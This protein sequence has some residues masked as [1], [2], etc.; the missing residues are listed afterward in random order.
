MP[1]VS[2]TNQRGTRLHTRVIPATRAAGLAVIAL[3]IPLHNLL[4]FGQ[5]S[6]YPAQLFA[7]ASALYCLATWF[8]LRSRFARE[9]R[10]DL[11]AL[12]LATDIVLLLFAINLTGGPRS[13]LF[14]LLAARCTDQLFFGYRRVT[15]FNYLLIGF[16]L[17]FLFYYATYQAPVDWGAESMKMIV[18]YSFNVYYGLSA[19][20]VER[21]RARQH[22]AALALRDRAEFIGSLRHAI[23]TRASGVAAQVE[24]LKRTP[25]E[26]VQRS[27]IHSLAETSE[28]LLSLIGTLG[29]SEQDS[30]WTKVQSGLFQPAQLLQEVE[31]FIR[32]FAASKGVDLRVGADTDV[33]IVMTGDA[34]KIRQVLL[35]LAHNAVRFTEIGFVELKALRA[36]PTKIT[37]WVRD[38]GAGVPQHVMRRV[39]AGLTRADGSVWRRLDAGPSGLAVSKK[40]ADLMGGS[41]EI[42]TEPGLGTTARLTL[43]IPDIGRREPGEPRGHD[44]TK[45]AKSPDLPKPV[46]R[47]NPETNI[48]DS[49]PSGTV[50]APGSTGLTP[51]PKTP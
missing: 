17:L 15:R 27:Q 3:L 48:D 34:A 42:E 2:S 32:P 5:L 1:L 14:L 43:D 16:Y 37:F 50:P 36:S 7:G 20:S 45:L 40:L 33:P 26:P 25:L 9:R 46:G 12:F 23:S 22:M 31:S 44:A 41:L 10:S 19:K 35:S 39:F 4:V 18:L 38:T 29:C 8:A 49:E 47:F 13:W 21:L 51:D 30:Q 28:S 11:G 6:L 24:A